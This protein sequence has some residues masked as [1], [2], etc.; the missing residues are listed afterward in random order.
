MNT[1]QSWEAFEI[2]SDYPHGASLSSF[3]QRAAEKI[4]N[5]IEMIGYRFREIFLAIQ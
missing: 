3:G 1:Q 2:P 5:H 4:Y